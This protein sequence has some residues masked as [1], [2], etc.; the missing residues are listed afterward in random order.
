MAI[1]PAWSSE[2]ETNVCRHARPDAQEPALFVTIHTPVAMA[3]DLRRDRPALAESRQLQHIVSEFGLRLEPMYTNISDPELAAQFYVLTPNA[4]VAAEFRRRIE[5][6]R[7][8]EAV[9]V[10]PPEGP[11]S[12]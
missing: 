1:G 9:Y 11:P 2:T 10:K 4:Q 5:D 12:G 8:V 3:R 6:A 7:V